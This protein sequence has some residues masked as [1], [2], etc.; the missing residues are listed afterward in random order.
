MTRRIYQELGPVRARQIAFGLMYSAA[1]GLLAASVIGIGLGAGRFAGWRASPWTLA[2]ILVAG[3][4]LGLMAGLMRSKTWETAAGAVDSHYG[5]KDRAKT[6]LAFL[7]LPQRTA[8]HELQVAD[9]AEHLASVE[10]KV[11]VPFRVPKLIPA[12][13]FALG[14]ALTLAIMPLAGQKAQAGL[15]PPRPE[16]IE[17]HDRLVEDLKQLDELVKEQKD[18]KLD[19]M[20]AELKRK[21]EELK[22]P[23]V[24]VKE[25]LAKLSEMQAAIAN[26]QA[27]YNTGLVDGKLQS[28]GEAMG[29]AES[30]EAAGTA[31]QDAKFEQAAK[32]L[33]KLEN[34]ELDKKEAK[35]VEE[36]LKQVA[37]A[38][39]D[40]GL[41]Q[42]GEAATELAEG[43]QGGNKGQISKGAKK[44]AGIAR[45]HAKRSNITRLLAAQMECLGECKS[46][47]NGGEK[48]Q[49]N[50]KSN[51]ASQTWGLAVAGNTEG[52]KTSL[53]S[54]RNL[55]EI[56]GNP[57]DVGDSEMETTHSPEGRQQ[58]A[59]SYKDAYKKALK[60]SE[61]VLDSEPIPLGHRQTIRK[62][63]EL[64]RPQNDASGDK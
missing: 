27:Q 46:Q 51:S 8:W 49:T 36:K 54:K 19:A 7:N 55:K 25:A 31:L 4:T 43:I 3:P 32:E 59:R 61:A 37:K 64:I 35:A 48:K 45:N 47:C 13:A 60:Q 24:D 56:T 6:A 20:L 5:L 33:E 11:V 17:V 53:A 34:P 16:I 42:M 1:A 26:Q 40:A 23:G 9:A 28:L 52:E 39:G 15:T 2:A 63:F 57:G 29:A 44:L 21:V 58:A 22:Q 50:K 38:M 41:G 18:K 14:I 12:A 30:L 62:Y 10:P